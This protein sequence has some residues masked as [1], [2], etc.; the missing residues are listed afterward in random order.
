MTRALVFAIR[1]A[2]VRLGQLVLSAA[3][4]AGA[5]AAAVALL[6]TS[7]WLISRAA[8]QPPILTLTVAIVGVRAFSVLRAALRYAERLVSHDLAFRALAT[9]RRRFFAAL[10]PL[11]PGAV[12]LRSGDLLS[13]FVADVDRLQDLY[14]RALHPPAVAAIAIVLAGVA[15]ALLLPAAG[16]I[17]VV[18]L[19]LAAV[20]VPL[21]VRATAR[22]AGRRQAPARA[23]L[24]AELVEALDGAGELAVCG[25]AR[26]RLERV[27]R[28]DAQLGRLAV[29]DAIAGGLAAASG[30]LLAGAALVACALVAVPAVRAGDLAGVALASL[31]LITLASFEAVTP[32]PVA[33]QHL[34]G[35]AAAAGRLRDVVER[36]AA[37]VD[38]GV[39]RTPSGR[40]ALVVEDVRV[41]GDDGEPILDGVSLALRPGE[42]VALV[43][44]SGAGKTTLAE[45]LVRFRDPDAGRV[46]LDGVDL[47]EM[48]QDDVRRAVVLAGQDAHLF[49][50]TIRENLLLARRSATEAELFDAL[51]LVG[52]RGW[53]EALPDGLDTLVGEEGATVSGGQRRRLA[54][55]RALLADARFLILDEPAAHLDTAAARDVAERLAA[56]PDDRAVLL[57][58]HTTV[59]LSA[60][61]RVVT[62]QPAPGRA[63]AGARAA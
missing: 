53:V 63:H 22:G 10:V 3:L 19:V 8:E 37:V 54:L 45:L 16:A 52:L 20:G 61:D 27:A 24:T 41:D 62:L 23:A 51:E 1:A 6:A 46:T 48:R 7:G 17:L 14:V 43:G 18:A 49:T 25:R 39:P 32:L 40:G 30:P 47:R 44:P 31:L 56:L 42:R 9:L 29:R 57:I 21:L 11:V 33:A 59:G 58:T 12:R 55:A 26:D 13:R 28:A 15:S 34:A 5:V 4:G 2:G 50:T 36:P 35:C 38:P 60:F